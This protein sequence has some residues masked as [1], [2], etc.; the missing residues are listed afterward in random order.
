MLRRN[1]IF[2]LLLRHSLA[3]EIEEW[4]W[5]IG[6]HSYGAKGSPIIIE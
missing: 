6:E 1:N 4:G 2:Q 3:Y 5:K